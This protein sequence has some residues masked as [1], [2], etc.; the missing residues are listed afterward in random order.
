MLDD[1]ILESFLDITP[2]TLAVRG[3]RQRK[4]S[5]NLEEFAAKDKEEH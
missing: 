5:F 1:T 3:M 2:K 4:E